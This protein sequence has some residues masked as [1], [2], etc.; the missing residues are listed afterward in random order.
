MGGEA[1]AANALL[2][3]GKKG[4]RKKGPNLALVLCNQQ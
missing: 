2:V 3:G 4:K 1:A